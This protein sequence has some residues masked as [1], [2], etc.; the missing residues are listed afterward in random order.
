MSAD[1]IKLYHSALNDPRIG[2]LSDAAF[3]CLFDTLLLSARADDGGHLV[4]A[5]V[6]E[7]F[8]AAPYTSDALVEL[9]DAGLVKLEDGELFVSHLFGQVFEIGGE[10]NRSRIYPIAIRSQRWRHLRKVVFLRDGFECAR[11][12]YG[13]PEVTLHCHHL[14]YDNVGSE[15]PDDLIT[16]CHICHAKEHGRAVANIVDPGDFNMTRR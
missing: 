11:C 14:N 13:P 9:A 8:S 15:S 12:G 16:L 10:S 3:R 2:R 4:H 5:Q 1:W 7:F 6:G